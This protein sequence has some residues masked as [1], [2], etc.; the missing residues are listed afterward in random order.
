MISLTREGVFGN[1]G[2]VNR[3]NS[4]PEYQFILNADPI[5]AAEKEALKGC[6]NRLNL[7][8]SIWN[9]Y[10]TLLKTATKNSI[11]QVL[12]MKRG[13]E[14]VA[15]VILIKC[16][17]H[18]M[19]LTGF[20]PVVKL[21]KGLRLPV[22]IW[23]RSGIGAELLANP[24]FINDRYDPGEIL[25]RLLKYIEEKL[26]LSFI[27]D[28]S[29]NNNLFDSSVRLPYPDEGVIDM[30]E[31]ISYENYRKLHRNLKKKFRHYR[32]QG[33]FIEVIKGRMSDQDIQRVGQCVESTS[34]HSVFKLPYQE[35]YPAMCMASAAMEEKNI[36]HFVCRTETDFLGY[37]SF[38]DFGSHL[39]CLNGAFNRDL[40]STHHAYENM[41]AKVVEYA[42]E[43]SI[44]QI[45][46]GPVLN[47]T[48]RRMMH[49][50]LFTTIHFMS[51]N[52]LI[53]RGFPVILKRSRMMN[54]NVLQFSS[55][56]LKRE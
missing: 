54:K 18:G 16:F 1:F 50:F 11:P 53:R 20:K 48:K 37:H 12:R 6:L 19:T 9:L 46:F 49:Q 5:N 39:R 29:E 31:I 28:L 42:D 47:E 14:L 30:E 4:M 3:T 40:K 41:I 2:E 35:N 22:Y 21:M 34:K 43:N 24:G 51:N 15:V 45:F 13:E 7:N 27:L 32:N 44:K 8:D 36:V 25:P 56:G 26:L 10:D 52:P 23:M 33:G 38:M 17:D 55:A